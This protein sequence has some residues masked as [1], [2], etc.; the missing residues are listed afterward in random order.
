MDNVSISKI[1][2][3]IIKPGAEYIILA[4]FILLGSAPH[5]QWA[6]PLLRHAFVFTR[7]RFKVL[8][9]TEQCRVTLKQYGEIILL[10]NS[11][12]VSR[13]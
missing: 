4:K 12:L 6:R 3:L 11:L 13:R 7:I 8:L 2:K 10:Y 1:R 9:F 5:S